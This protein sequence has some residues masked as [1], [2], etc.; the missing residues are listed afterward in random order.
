MIIQTWKTW[1][2]KNNPKIYTLRDS[3]LGYIE[4]IKPTLQEYGFSYTEDDRDNDL[5]PKDNALAL[6]ADDFDGEIVYWVWSH[7]RGYCANIC[8]AYK[9]RKNDKF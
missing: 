3:T 6:M 8:V 7:S 9:A 4:T 5:S 2:K 1:K